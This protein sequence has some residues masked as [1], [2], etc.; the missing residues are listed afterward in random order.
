VRPS[1]AGGGKKRGIAALSIAPFFGGI[2]PADVDLGAGLSL[3]ELL[4]A[5]KATGSA[6]QT[7]RIAPI[8]APRA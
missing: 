1:T 6:Q 3:F 2:R 8:F 4:N 7:R 5:G